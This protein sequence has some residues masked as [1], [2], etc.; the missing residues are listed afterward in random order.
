MLELFLALQLAPD[1]RSYPM[2]PPKTVPGIL[3]YEDLSESAQWK[4]VDKLESW[5]FYSCLSTK[6]LKED[7]DAS[8][9]EVYR[10]VK[11]HR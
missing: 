1:W 11:T 10:P 9:A 4:L 6:L 7:L 3:H 8:S 2:E 5:G